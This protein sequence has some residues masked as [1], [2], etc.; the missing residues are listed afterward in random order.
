MIKNKNIYQKNIL[1]RWVSGIIVNQKAFIGS[2]IILFFGVLAIFVPPFIQSPTD[3]LSTPLSPPSSDYFFGTN[4]QGQDVFAQTICGARQTLFVGFSTGFLVVVI[5]A[6][7]GGCSG[8]FGG[9]TDDLLS[10]LIN[11]FLVMPSLPTSSINFPSLLKS[12]SSRRISLLTLYS[13]SSCLSL[14]EFQ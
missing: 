8:Y 13:I 7:I 12:L 6:I 9:R 4:G 3:F 10:F 1:A 5:G 14:V 11:I 2:C